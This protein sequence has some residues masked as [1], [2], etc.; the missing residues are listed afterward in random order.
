MKYREGRVE[1]KKPVKRCLQWYGQCMMEAE[2]RVEAEGRVEIYV[3]SKHL[4]LMEWRQT[5]EREMPSL[6]PRFPTLTMG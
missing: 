3:G 6:S 1:A 5:S 2:T 4:L